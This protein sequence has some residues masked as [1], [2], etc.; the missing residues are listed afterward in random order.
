MLVLEPGQATPATSAK[1]NRICWAIAWLGIAVGIFFRVHHLGSQSLWFDE[2]YTA[3]MVSHS[4]G[5]II[6]LI[7][8]DTAPPLYYLLLRGW[9]DLFGRSEIAL[10]SLSAVFS[11]ITMFVALD[12]ARKLLRNPVAIAAVAWAMALSFMQIWYAQEARAYALMALLGVAAFDFL[13]YHLAERGRRWLAP[14][15]MTIAAAMYMHNMMGRRTLR[16]W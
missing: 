10:R 4:P 7:R 13:L 2:G 11:I 14:L 12:I 1:M 8:A 16:A 6:R 15:A 3:W 5:E 9:T